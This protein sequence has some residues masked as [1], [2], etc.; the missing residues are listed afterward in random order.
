MAKLKIGVVGLP[1][2]WSTETL[3]KAVQ[4]QT[5]FSLIIDMNEV[6]LD[7][8]TGALMYEKENLC[9]FDALIIKKISS[10]YS[11]NTLDRLELLRVAE[12]AG[13]AIFSKPESILRLIDRLSCTVTLSNA[14]IPMP[15][16]RVTESIA[17]AIVAVKD[18]GSA[19]FKPLYSTKARGMCVINHTDGKTKILNAIQDF[20]ANNPMMYIQQ[21]V[22]LGGK[23]MGL[24]FLNNQYLGAYARVSKTNAWNTTIHSG[25][26]YEAAQPSQAIIKMADKAQRLFNMSYT[27]VDVAE[28]EQGAVIF[29]VSA[30]GGFRG[31]KE[32]VDLN[33]AE[34]YV[35][36]VLEK[37]ATIECRT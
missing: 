34:L 18:F 5:G 28:T 32:G 6:T 33:V 8:A 14:G 10:D 16:T 3:A 22:A 1:G 7:L 17:E 37:L 20:K 13:V 19:I 31:G 15:A 11:P 12:H 27:T 25:G 4:K 36:Y 29:E 35:E 9:Q 30:F 24:M 21:K 26:S 23:D 2:K